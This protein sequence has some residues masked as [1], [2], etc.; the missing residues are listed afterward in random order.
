[1]NLSS[2]RWLIKFSW[3]KLAVTHDGQIRIGLS[4]LRQVGAPVIASGSNQVF[5]LV[6]LAT[7]CESWQ[8]PAAQ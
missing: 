2:S 6:D 1:V 7:N 4:L 5:R 3:F 8:P